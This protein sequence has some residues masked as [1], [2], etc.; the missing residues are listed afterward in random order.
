MIVAAHVRTG[1]LYTLVT[2]ANERRWDKMKDQLET[3]AQSFVVNT[4]YG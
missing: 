4:K 1:K 2:G 3:V